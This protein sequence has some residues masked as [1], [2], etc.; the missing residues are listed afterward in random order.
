MTNGTWLY[1]IK[2]LEGQFRELEHDLEESRR[3]LTGDQLWHLAWAFGIALAAITGIFGTALWIVITDQ[4]SSAAKAAAIETARN[5]ARIAAKE[6]SRTDVVRELAKDSVFLSNTANTLASLFS[7]AVVAFDNSQGCPEGWTAFLPATSRVI[8]GTGTQD[9]LKKVPSEF[10]S[11][12]TARPFRQPGGEEKHVLLPD[13]MASHGHGA[14]ELTI[15]DPEGH[16]QS[17]RCA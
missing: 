12:L 10:S 16:H 11:D 13:E 2:S 5:E 3:R 8:I 17:G 6:V 15:T 1:R 7:N 14:A 4:A 9:D